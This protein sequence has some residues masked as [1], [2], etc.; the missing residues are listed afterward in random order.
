MQ[1]VYKWTWSSLI[2]CKTVW[3]NNHY[4]D[5]WLGSMSDENLLFAENIESKLK[6]GWKSKIGCEL[7]IIIEY[8]LEIL[9]K[10][11]KSKFW[12]RIQNRS[13]FR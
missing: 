2:N 11:L 4:V 10:N 12:I 8:W 6:T 9:K 1:F 7:Q 5:G 3:Y 13:I